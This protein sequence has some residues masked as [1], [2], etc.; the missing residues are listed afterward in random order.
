MM[1][2][3]IGHRKW[4]KRCSPWESQHLKKKLETFDISDAKRADSNDQLRP[5]R[6]H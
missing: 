6:D 1:T 3:N 4:S 2:E 5:H